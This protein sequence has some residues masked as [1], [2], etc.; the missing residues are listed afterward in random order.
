MPK[1]EIVKN[2]QAG[3]PDSRIDQV[4][5]VRDGRRYAICR[6]TGRLLAK[7]RDCWEYYTPEVISYNQDNYV[8]RMRKEFFF[9]TQKAALADI[10]KKLP[11][12]VPAQIFLRVQEIGKLTLVVMLPDRARTGKGRNYFVHEQDM[13]Y[14]Q[15]DGNPHYIR[16]KKITEFSITEMMEDIRKRL[17]D[18]LDNDVNK[19]IKSEADR[20]SDAQAI[21]RALDKKTEIVATLEIS[22]ITWRDFDK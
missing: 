6:T 12:K 22:P 7:D 13:V 17:H 10:A 15:A 1:L 11:G 4:D 3:I 20:L 14:V 5:L 8:K 21:C 2:L 16:V 18:I 19:T 9:S